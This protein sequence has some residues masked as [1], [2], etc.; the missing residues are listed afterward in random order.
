MKKFLVLFFLTCGSSLFAQAFRIEIG[1]SQLRYSQIGALYFASPSHV[2]TWYDI[3]TVNREL[4]SPGFIFNGYY[5]LNFGKKSYEIFSFG[6]QIGLAMNVSH[7]TYSVDLNYR[8]LP[9]KMNMRIPLMFSVRL[10]S[11]SAVY[12][13]KLGIAIAGG[14]E[15]MQLQL[16]DQTGT[17]YLPVIQS[18]FAIN[19]FMFN[20][21]AYPMDIESMYT[22]NGADVPRLTTSLLEFQFVIAIDGNPPRYHNDAPK[23]GKN[24]SRRR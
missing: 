11:T 21:N 1:Y 24:R 5:P 10:G 4:K 12:Q 13:R 2:P 7:T 15:M 6:P 14:I 8:K 18:S 20:V 23:K 19:R 22:I 16:A 17:F 9:S 3:A